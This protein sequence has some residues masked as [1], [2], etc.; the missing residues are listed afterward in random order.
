MN[1]I[2]TYAT[3]VGLAAGAAVGLSACGSSNSSSS[4]SS[5]ASKPAA[6]A[7][8][9]SLKSVSGVGSVLVDSKGF[10]L[11]S[12]TQE[13]SGTIHCTASCTA[14]WIPLTLSQGV[15]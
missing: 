2:A 5:G 14:V 10:A 4:G 12:P 15:S 6:A 8:T 13:Q 1:R 11:Y 9:V 7:E 3:A